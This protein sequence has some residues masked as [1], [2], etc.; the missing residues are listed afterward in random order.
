MSTFSKTIICGHLGDNPKIHH[1]EG[2]GT[3]ARFPV[4]T[5]E[6]WKDKTTGE[7]KERTEWHNVTVR[8]K[9]AELAEKYLAKGSKVLVEGKNQTRKWTNDAGVDQYTT[10]IIAQNVTFMS[11]RGDSGT[12]TGSAVDAYQN[13]Q[14]V[15][16]NAGDQF[17]EGDFKA[18]QDDE[19]DLPF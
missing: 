14:N 4:A 17:L 6:H 15:P 19:D 13:K 18:K 9:Q 3:I 7:K 11:P 12:N 16:Q 8:N 1:F 2:G 5:T 10:E